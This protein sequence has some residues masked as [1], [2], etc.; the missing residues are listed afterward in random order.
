VENLRFDDK[1]NLD[2]DAIPGVGVATL[3]LQSD[4]TSNPATI[5]A[6]ATRLDIG[7]IRWY[8][9]VFA[10]PVAVTPTLPYYLRVAS[11]GGVTFTRHDAMEWQGETDYTG[12]QF[13]VDGVPLDASNPAGVWSDAYFSTYSVGAGGACSTPEDANVGWTVGH[14]SSLNAGMLALAQ[15]FVPN[16]G[17]G[18]CKVRVVLSDSHYNTRFSIVRGQI[19]SLPVGPAG[20]DEI[21]MDADTPP[22]LDPT[23]PDIGT[24]FFYV[25]RGERACGNTSYGNERRNTPGGPVLTPRTTA[26]CP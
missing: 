20:L 24:G 11:P 22:M 17:Y 12:G 6:Q 21:C 3:Y 13:F 2:F 5:Y 1:T 16:R 15:S 23:T 8:E 10:S 25:I 18:L 14:G 26:T 4:P 7:N 9:F 19:A